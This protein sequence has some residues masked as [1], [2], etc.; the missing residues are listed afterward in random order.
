MSD[1]QDQ[2]L[3]KI[4]QKIDRLADA[5]VSIAR[6]EERVA[7]VLKQNDRFFIRM[8]KME[9]RVDAVENKSSLNTRSFSFLERFLW[10]CVSSG[11]GLLV[12]FL[13]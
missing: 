10:V 2:R 1:S 5:V 8:D 12:Y 11:V 7:T 4:E 13:R 3:E 6:I 9:E